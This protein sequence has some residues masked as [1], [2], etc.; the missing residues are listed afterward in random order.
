MENYEFKSDTEFQEDV[1]GKIILCRD[2][3]EVHL[4]SATS[5][6]DVSGLKGREDE[7][8]LEWLTGMYVA[9][10]ITERVGFH[11]DMPHKGKILGGANILFMDNKLY[12]NYISSKCGPVHEDVIK[13]CLEDTE[14]KVIC[15]EDVYTS[16]SVS[17]EK[18][19]TQ[20]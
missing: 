14:I 8:L 10:D 7:K 18:Y 4:N 17:L 11:K 20:E 13:K 3:T 19:L 6:R 2:G 15:G 1:V 16:D 12:V 5:E 9:M